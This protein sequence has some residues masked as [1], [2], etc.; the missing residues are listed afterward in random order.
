VSTAVVIGSL[1]ADVITAAADPRIR[2]S[3]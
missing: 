2:L 3:A 1:V